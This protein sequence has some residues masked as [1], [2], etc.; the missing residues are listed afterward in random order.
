M[1]QELVNYSQQIN[2]A[3]SECL[4]AKELGGKKAHECGTWLLK[5]KEALPHG[6]WIKWVEQNCPFTRDMAQK[7]MAIGRLNEERVIHLTVR[8]CLWEVAAHKVEQQ[9][10]EEERLADI[11]RG[12]KPR[13]PTQMDEF[14][15][16]LRQQAAFRKRHQEYIDSLPEEQRAEYQKAEQ[17]RK[18]LEYEKMCIKTDTMRKLAEEIIKLGYRE[19]SKLHHPDAGGQHEDMVLLPEIKK[20]LVGYVN[21]KWKAEKQERKKVA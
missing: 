5:Q 21:R 14:V 3:H 8:D 1:S 17:R 11:A 2:A 20:A 12:K 13:K 16:H 19:A 18:A 10:I 6:Q 7:Y 9:E 4:A 15:E